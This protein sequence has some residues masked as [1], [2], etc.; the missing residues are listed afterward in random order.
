MIKTKSGVLA[1]SRTAAVHLAVAAPRH[2]V[3]SIAMKNLPY[4]NQKLKFQYIKLKIR[5]TFANR[6]T[7]QAT[8]W[9]VRGVNAGRGKI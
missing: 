1:D 6:Y 9:K 4:K 7:D 3:S 2:R 8:S 5:A